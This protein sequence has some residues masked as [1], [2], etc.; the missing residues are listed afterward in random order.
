MSDKKVSVKNRSSSIVVY[1][2]PEMGVRREFAPNETKLVTMAEL[3]ALS[4]LPGGMALIHKNLFISDAAVLEDM[5]VK[6]EPEYYLDEAGVIDLLNNGSIDAF[7]DCLDF[8]P[9]G[10][11]DLIKKLSVTIPMTDINKRK[12]LKEKTGF[13]VEA[14][15]RNIAAEQ[16]DDTQNTILKQ[17]NGER[18]VKEDVPAGR[19][20]APKYN[21]VTKPADAADDAKAE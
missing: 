11:L 18:R 13:D 1:S 12:T 4:Y 21:I 17:S 8:S 15:L 5:S 20:T 2:V 3:N 6:V 16:E 10:V 14:A 7:L 9:E 19:R